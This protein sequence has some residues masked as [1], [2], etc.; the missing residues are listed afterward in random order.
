[1]YT[2]SRD[3]SAQIASQTLTNSTADDRKLRDTEHSCDLEVQRK[4]LGLNHV[5]CRISSTL[6]RSEF[7][8]LI[9]DRTKTFGR[10]RTGLGHQ[11]SRPSCSRLLGFRL[12]TQPLKTPISALYAPN[13]Y[14]RAFQC[15][16]CFA[17]CVAVFA[18]SD[19]GDR[20]FGLLL[21]GLKIGDRSA[22]SVGE[23]GGQIIHCPPLSPNALLAFLGNLH[24]AERDS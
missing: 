20:P 18:V 3:G 8:M 19:V 1:M 6:F 2:R 21:C 15:A 11:R 14:C 16:L 24:I 23:G 9:N 22:A 7:E 4:Y 12:P 17:I 5:D 13:S 10:V